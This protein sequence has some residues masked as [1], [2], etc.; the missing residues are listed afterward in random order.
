MSTNQTN[1]PGFSERLSYRLKASVSSSIRQH[2]I[3][4]FPSDRTSY[5]A[6]QII[7]IDINS[8]QFLDPLNSFIELH[9]VPSATTRAANMNV[10]GDISRIISKFKL[11]N[12]TGTVP[13]EINDVGLLQKILIEHSV[14]KD[15]RNTVLEESGWSDKWGAGSAY[16][17]NA[18]VFAPTA[19]ALTWMNSTGRYYKL[20]LSFSG[21]LGQISQYVC[22]KQLGALKLELTLAPAATAI[23]Y[24]TAGSTANVVGAEYTVSRV[25][26]NASLLTLSDDIVRVV[27]ESARKGNLK[28]SY[29]TY[30]TNTFA[31][32][33]AA[34]TDGTS[35]ETEVQLKKSCFDLR[36]IYG[37]V[38]HTANITNPLTD[39]FDSIVGARVDRF[40][41]S[42]GTT[43]IP[44]KY[45]DNLLAQYCE[46]Q[47]AFAKLNSTAT[48]SVSYT[49]FSG[50]KHL[51]GVDL[52]RDPT[53]VNTGFSTNN[54]NFA[55][56]S[57]R[58]SAS[59][60]DLPACS[61]TCF[62]LYTRMITIMD[63][64]N[65]LLKE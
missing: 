55:S 13:E 33:T 14:G 18:T 29:P 27:D 61:L 15:Y 31:S 20:S 5:N 65:V 40:Q 49:E 2:D 44:S 21:L 47:R 12:V 25:F 22:L 4:Y 1:I 6:G 53:S 19:P 23:I 48:A 59:G 64:A 26:Y 9:M 45:V 36:S 35:A 57:V 39:S 24:P 62:S 38:R 11:S 56:I 41:T 51:I 17:D 37:V 34:T 30:F 32:T 63:N 52:E 43:Y 10:S 54:G 42:I 60:A 8:Q 16:T 46:S 50:A 28:I 3:K 58:L 7:T